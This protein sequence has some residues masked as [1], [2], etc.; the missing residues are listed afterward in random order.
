[1][2]STKNVDDYGL[3]QDCLLCLRKLKKAFDQDLLSFLSIQFIPKHF[4]LGPNVDE[5]ISLLI[6]ADLKQ[7]K[8]PIKQA[9]LQF[10]QQV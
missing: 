7:A 8:K 3:V 10:T 4:K 9:L 6:L 2:A 1:M 5:L